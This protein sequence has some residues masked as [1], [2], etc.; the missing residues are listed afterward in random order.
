MAKATHDVWARFKFSVVGP[1]LAAPPSGGALREALAR[2][3]Q[4]TWRHPITGEGVCFAFSTIERWYYTA[5]RTDNPV[6]ALRRAVRKDAGRPRLVSPRLAAYLRTQYHE[7]RPWSY[8]LHYDNLV[9]AMEIEPTL[10]PLPSYPTVVRWMKAHALFRQKRRGN[11]H[12]PGLERARARLDQREVRSYEVE[13]VGALW[14][15]RSTA[16]C[17]VGVCWSAQVPILPAFP[18]TALA[19]CTA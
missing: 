12:R 1:L 18:A 15:M 19:A 3:S 10:G 4:R 14:H 9:V 6:E 7:H 13:H 11:T 17:G 2:L 5:A 8:R 16:I